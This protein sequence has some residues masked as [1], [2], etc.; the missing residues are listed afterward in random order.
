M[1]TAFNYRGTAEA[2]LRV[3]ARFVIQVEITKTKM[4]SWRQPFVLC[5]LFSVGLLLLLLLLFCHAT[6]VTNL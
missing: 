3:R 1:M 4:S 6:I 5:H 2:K